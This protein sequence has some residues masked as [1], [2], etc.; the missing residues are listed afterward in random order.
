VSVASS[1][2]VLF[3]SPWIGP[4]A[5]VNIGAVGVVTP[6]I[7]GIALPDNNPLAPQ[8]PV[9]IN[10]SNISIVKVDTVKAGHTLLGVSLTAFDS[11][12]L[13]ASGAP[14]VFSTPAGPVPATVVT[15]I[16]GQASTTWTPLDSAATYTLTGVR[17]TPLATLA[18]STGRIILRRSVLVVAADPDATKSTVEIAATT[19]AAN[20]N[21]TV[22]VKI[23]DIFNNLVKTTVPADFTVTVTRGAV[24]AF[25]C[26][27]GAC[28]A[29]YT[30][31]ATAGAD[32]ISVQ[33]GGIEIKFSPLV[34]TIT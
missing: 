23:R 31:P 17:T 29:T 18:D 2:G 16:N 13:P 22:T 25:T 9:T 33:I 26:V 8:V 21:A 28:T 11:T 1:V 10:P 24:G 14:V 7:T 20:G 5:I 3:H 15:D 27:N 32:G 4:N 34:L 12:G 30:A 6:D 19:I